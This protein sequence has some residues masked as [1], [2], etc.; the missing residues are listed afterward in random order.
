M[1]LLPAVMHIKCRYFTN[2]NAVVHVT[3]R[4]TLDF[5]DG[6]ELGKNQEKV[7]KGD[8]ENF[9]EKS[10]R[11]VPILDKKEEVIGDHGQTLELQLDDV[12]G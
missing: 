6:I 8:V 12:K 1:Y 10:D 5:S 4:L 11:K 9:E 2:K 3:Q 7:H